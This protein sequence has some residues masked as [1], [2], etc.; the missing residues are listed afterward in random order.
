M[1]QKSLVAG[2]ETKRLTRVT[3]RIGI[4]GTRYF[5]DE[6]AWNANIDHVDSTGIVRRAGFVE[7]R[8]CGDE[9]AGVFGDDRLASGSAGVAIEAAGKINGHYSLYGAID[10]L[11]R[12]AVRWLRFAGR[13]GAQQC[14]N[15]PIGVG[16][17]WIKLRDGNLFVEKLELDAG[18][19]KNMP[20]GGSVAAKLRWIGKQEYPDRLATVVEMARNYESVPAVV[21]LA[22]TND[23][24]TVDAKREERIGHSTAGVL[25]QHQAGHAVVVNRAAI[26]LAD[27]I[28]SKDH[29]MSWQPSPNAIDAGRQRDRLSQE[30]MRAGSLPSL[31]QYGGEARDCA[32]LERSAANADRQW[33]DVARR[34]T[35]RTIVAK[36]IDAFTR[37][38]HAHLVGEHG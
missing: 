30:Q 14:I 6:A 2:R 32:G 8:L 12:R 33:L 25:H 37:C 27:L 9:R 11:D 3:E 34:A 21:A 28:A 18:S 22:A 26:D 13:T 36:R 35:T 31:G 29:A 23:D 20:I 16:E 10:G 17:M 4:L 38:F 15:D 24:G 5:A 7:T 19:I 1:A